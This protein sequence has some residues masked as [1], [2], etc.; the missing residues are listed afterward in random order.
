MQSAPSA[1]AWPQPRCVFA[2]AIVSTVSPTEPLPNVYCF[3]SYI[4]PAVAIAPT[5][6]PT[7]TSVQIQSRRTVFTRRL[8]QAITTRLLPVKSSAPAMTTSTRPSEKTRPP[9]SRVT[10]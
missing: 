5:K 4:R 2:E 10:P 1:T 9:S 6:F 3:V 8:A 7:Q